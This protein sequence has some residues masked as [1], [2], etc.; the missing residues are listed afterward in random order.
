MNESASDNDSPAPGQRLAALLALASVWLTTAGHTAC[1]REMDAARG[2]VTTDGYSLHSGYLFAIACGLAITWANMPLRQ[3]ARLMRYGLAL[4]AIGSF[5]N[6]LLLQAPFTLLVASRM[7]AGLGGGMVLAAAPI[8]GRAAGSR[9]FAWAGILLPSVGILII[10]KVADLY[11]EHGWDGAFLFEGTLALAAL[12]I[13]V[14]WGHEHGA[15]GWP[16]VPVWFPLLVG[17]LGCLW[18]AISYGQLQGWWEDRRSTLAMSGGVVFLALLVSTLILSPTVLPVSAWPTLV[19]AGFAGFVQYFNVSDMGVYG[20]GLLDLGMV[21]RSLLIWPISIGA[22]TAAMLAIVFKANRWLTVI[23]LVAIALGMGLAHNRTMDWPFWAALNQAQFNW[24]AAPGLWELAPARFLM[25]LGASL[26]LIGLQQATLAHPGDEVTRRQLLTF[27]QFVGGGISIGVLT[28]CTTRGYQ[29]EYSFVAERGYI[30]PEVYRE[31]GG[32]L[33]NHLHSQGFA[34]PE[35]GARSMLHN[36]V[37]YESNNMVFAT[38]YG[39]F[40]IWAYAFA[41]LVVV[42]WGWTW[43]RPQPA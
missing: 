39:A 2:W 26:T 30:Q 42:W 5:I 33:K 41:G 31:Y 21:D 13:L 25:G 12:L 17:F 7:I 8:A 19:I 27:F 9:W 37:V 4:L 36:S 20:G 32:I 35:A 34:S 18:Y 10:A 23:G 15:S 11:R 16:V 40:R 43:S 28:L 14:I 22:G 6:G 38:I 3:P 1:F 24:F 29:N